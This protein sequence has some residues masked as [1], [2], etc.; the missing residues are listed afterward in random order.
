M[1]KFPL[2]SSEFEIA[3]DELSTFL[4]TANDSEIDFVLEVDLDYRNALHIMHKGFPVAPTE[5]KIDR[6]LLSE[7]QMGLVDQ[8]GNRRVTRLTPVQTFLAKKIYT[9]FTLP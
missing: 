8:A 9:V 4:K 7:Y 2:P 6:K 5:E 1:P 3:D